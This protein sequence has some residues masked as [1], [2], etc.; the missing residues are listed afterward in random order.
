[1]SPFRTGYIR[2]P[3]SQEKLDSRLVLKVLF[4]STVFPCVVCVR[5]D[6]R[7]TQSTVE[8]L[9]LIG[10]VKAFIDYIRQE[11]KKGEVVQ[12]VSWRFGSLAGWFVQG[13]LLAEQLTALLCS[14]L[15][16][17]DGL[18]HWLYH[19]LPLMVLELHVEFIRAVI[20]G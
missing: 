14:I 8:W 7:K 5:K 11:P 12:I 13:C 20:P 6:A 9:T 19:T 16:V 1:M 3:Q 2:Q 10:Y 4:I 18:W 15:S 17:G